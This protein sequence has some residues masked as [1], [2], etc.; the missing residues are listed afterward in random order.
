MKTV[1]LHT[2]TNC[3]DGE[4]TSAELIRLAW[5]SG[6]SAVAVTDHDTV[7]GIDE[8]VHEGNEL[9]IEVVPGMELSSR[10]EG[11]DVHLVCLYPDTESPVLRRML[12]EFRK[13]RERRNEEILGRLE[14]LGLPVSR[15]ELQSGRGG[16]VTR[17]NIAAAM[18]RH[19]NTG[20]VK[21]AF[22]KYLNPGMPA[23]VPKQDPEPE[24][25]IRV[26]HEAGALVFLAHYHQIDRKDPANAVRLARRVLAAGADGLETRYSEFDEKMQQVAEQMAEEFGCL[27]SGGSDFHGAV[28]PGLQI[29]TGY[30]NL[31]VP[32]EYLEK[33]K[34]AHAGRR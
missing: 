18:M 4:L 8:A 21:E 33:I 25:G 15:A 6:L 23:Y 24:E 19:G 22:S 34:E 26:M 2:H 32:Y 13:R 16:T 27:R 29:G 7:A 3:S 5:Q 20:S 11:H 30:G 31:A 12:A 9:G 17:A 28:K 1:D 10:L 14:H